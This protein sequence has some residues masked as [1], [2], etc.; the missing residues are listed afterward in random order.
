[1]GATIMTKILEV[2]VRQNPDPY[3]RQYQLYEL[4]LDNELI[5]AQIS[6]L[7]LEEIK[8]EMANRGLD[9]I[10]PGVLLKA[11]PPQQ[12]AESSFGLATRSINNPI[13]PIPENAIVVP[14]QP[15]IPLKKVE[16]SIGY[17]H[18]SPKQKEA[19]EALS[20]TEI[21]LLSELA[22]KINSLPRNAL[23]VARCLK[24]KGLIELSGGNDFTVILTAAGARRARV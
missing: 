9:W 4:F 11:L 20:E 10:G 14:S 7:G 21:L 17:I 22:V 8:T 1:M 23:A 2:R 19:L 6:Y 16:T 15:T 12:Q 18:L 13:S 24:D 5:R 3:A